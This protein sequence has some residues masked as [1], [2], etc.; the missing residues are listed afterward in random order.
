VNQMLSQ[1]WTFLEPVHDQTFGL[2]FTLIAALLLWL[3]RSKVKLIYGRA[4]N[5]I[6]H[7]TIPDPKDEKNASSIEIYVEKFFLQNLGWK[8]ANDVEFVLSAFPT[9]INVWQP[10]DVE[11]KRVAKGDCLVKIPCIAPKELVIIDCV[12]LNMRAAYVTSVKCSEALGKE[13]PFQTFRQYPAWV[14]WLFAA[15]LFFGAAFCFQLAFS[16]FFV[17][18]PSGGSPP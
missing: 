1:M 17:G 5:S 9:D 6:N 10:R 11:F 7:V 13:V 3:F 16:L 14:N 8:P 4:N 18:I 2:G 12:Y 15:L